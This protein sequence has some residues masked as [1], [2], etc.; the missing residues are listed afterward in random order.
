MERKNMD[1][2]GNAAS[3]VRCSPVF[4]SKLEIRNY[5]CRCGTPI[6]IPIKPDYTDPLFIW[7]LERQVEI[8]RKRLEEVERQF[9]RLARECLDAGVKTSIMVEFE[10]AIAILKAY[11][12]MFKKP[13]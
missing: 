13:E 6:S 3:P 5:R 10:E 9:M 8:V 1:K 11:R 2:E 12:D 4:P 7:E